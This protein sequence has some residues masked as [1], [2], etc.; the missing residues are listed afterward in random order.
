[1]IA[2]LA[3]LV[4]ATGVCAGVG[5]VAAAASEPTVDLLV[6]TDGVHFTTA[7][8]GGLFDKSVLLVP[9]GSAAAGL[10]IKNP[11]NAP[12]VLRVSARDIGISSGDLADGVILSAWNSGTDT[13][14]SATLADLSECEVLVPSQPIAPE[15]T[16]QVIIRY[17]MA[18]LAGVIAQHESTSLGLM[19]AMRDAEAGPFPESACQDDG[20]LI[21]P[22]PAPS[23]P[24]VP[25][26]TLATTGTGFPVSLLAAGGLLVGIGLFLAVRRRRRNDES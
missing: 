1:M 3:A 19:V 18:N 9:E 8:A 10:W 11:T 4:L 21:P 17:T 14:R 5:P 23:S 24:P 7:L 20:V 6:S 15:A 16:T 12:A 13:T 2:A 22:I 26:S 25:P